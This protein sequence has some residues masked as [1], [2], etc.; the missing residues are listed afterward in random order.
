MISPPPAADFS[1]FTPFRRLYADTFHA[2][3]FAAAATPPMQCQLSAFRRRQA[4]GFL[5]P[6]ADFRQTTDHCSRHRSSPSFRVSSSPVQEEHGT[7]HVQSSRLFRQQRSQ[8]RRPAW[9]PKYRHSVTGSPAERHR[10]GDGDRKT[11]TAESLP[12]PPAPALPLF[13]LIPLRYY[14]CSPPARYYLLRCSR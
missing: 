12:L 9:Q 14:R 13:N 1:S 4:A 11:R 8:V 2:R 7:E 5:M 10:N 6:D 3:H